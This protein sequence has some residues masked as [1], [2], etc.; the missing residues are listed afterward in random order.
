MGSGKSRCPS[1]SNSWSTV[2]LVYINSICSNLSNFTKFKLFA[3]GTSLFSV[4][5][6]ANETFE[7]LN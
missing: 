5:N 6:D 4:V 1:N 7:N 3:D 2:S